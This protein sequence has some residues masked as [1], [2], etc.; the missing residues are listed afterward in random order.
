MAEY[1]L[2]TPDPDGSVIRTTDSACIP[3]DPAN[4]D[5]RDYQ[6]WLADGGVPDPYVEPPPPAPQQVSNRQFYQQ[7]AVDGL[8]SQNDALEAMSGTLPGPVD[9]YVRSLPSA[10]QFGAEMRFKA[11]GFPRDDQYVTGLLQF[12]GAADIDQ[13][14]IAASVV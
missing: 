13:F 4:T 5:W 1:R 8:I 10:M 12:L 6:A 7:A 2:T 14:F 9:S 11:T 3:A